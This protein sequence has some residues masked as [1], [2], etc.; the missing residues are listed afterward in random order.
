MQVL[1][2]LSQPTNPQRPSA[3]TIGSFDGVHLGH[4][5]L[6][7]TMRSLVGEKGS[8][9]VITFSNHPSHVLP[10][11]QPVEPILDNS[12]KLKWLE[13]F[14]VDIVYCIPFTTEL[15]AMD[16]SAFLQAVMHACP[17]DHLVLG[18]GARLGADRGGSPEKVTLLCKEMGATAHYL[19]KRRIDGNIISSRS[20]RKLLS[21]GQV[22]EATA[23]LGHPL[24][25]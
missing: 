6:L 21:E 23:L 9:C 7:A 1:D 13:H 8:L 10:N 2:D 11:Q 17:F 3:L 22:E 19:E 14:R 25:G 5:H 20:I 4:Q 24:H 15:A 12:M 16:Y 18:E